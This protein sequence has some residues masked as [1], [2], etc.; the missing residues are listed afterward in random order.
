V[1]EGLGAPSEVVPVLGGGMR[2]RGVARPSEVVP[3]LAGI[4]ETPWN[5]L[6]CEDPKPDQRI[7]GSKDQRSKNKS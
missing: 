3:V 6:V 2:G 5:C 7:K 4:R 1:V